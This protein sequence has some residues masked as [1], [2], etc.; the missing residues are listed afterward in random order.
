[1]PSPAGSLRPLADRH[2]DPWWLRLVC[3]PR[4]KS[5]HV[6]G[7]RGLLPLTCGTHSWRWPFWEVV[8]LSSLVFIILLCLL[9]ETSS[10]KILYDRQRRLDRCSR[11]AAA[12]RRA[13]EPAAAP[14][15][16]FSAVLHRVLIRPSLILLTNPAILFANIYTMALYGCYYSFFESF[17]QVYFYVYH[18]KEQ[19]VG[20]AFLS[21]S[22]G[23]ALGLALYLPWA[24]WW[25]RNMHNLGPR[26]AEKCLL[27]AVYGSLLIPVGL[28]M[29]GASFPLETRLRRPASPLL[30][31]TDATPSPQ[32][33]PRAQTSTGA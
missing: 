21:I 17:P 30:P 27:P 11:S 13:A 22:I 9:P 18:F 3:S 23:S 26:Q 16:T 28:F 5:I 7:R 14:G 25:S 24:R 6:R 4:S 31:T 12:T 10:A 15:T 8:W 20:L 32:H 29:F 33:G 1:M 19:D 2:W